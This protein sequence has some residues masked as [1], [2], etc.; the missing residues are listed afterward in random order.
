MQVWHFC[1]L[2]RLVL[3]AI[4]RSARGKALSNV[5]P[6]NPAWT[7]KRRPPVAGVAFRTDADQ[8]ASQHGDRQV[9]GIGCKG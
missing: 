3:P 8:T 2:V 1:G 5:S 6:R 4:F 7:R 9:N